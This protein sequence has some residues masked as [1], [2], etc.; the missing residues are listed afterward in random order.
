MEEHETT[1]KID[2]EK[3]EKSTTE[4]TTKV[5][6]ASP[7]TPSPSSNSNATWWGGWISQAKEK[8]KLKLILDEFSLIYSCHYFQSASVLEAVRNDLNEITTAVTE[9]LNLVPTDEELNNESEQDPAGENSGGVNF[10][11]MK[12]SI[13]SSI[14]TFFGSV[15]DALVPQL[16]E[17]DTSEAILISNDD[18]VVLTGFSKHLK[19]LQEN[20]ETYLEE[21][22]KTA[23]AEKYRMWLEIVEQDQFTQPRIEKMLQQSQVLNEK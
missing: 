9:T 12:Q 7:T 3:V 8:V 22:S 10:T 11:H 15:T 21:P 13:S 20:D 1:T 18:S 2:D 17:D 16:D 23:L 5:K 4:T 14:S 6:D 19:E